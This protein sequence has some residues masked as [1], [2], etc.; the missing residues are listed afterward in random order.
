MKTNTQVVLYGAGLR[1]KLDVFET[2]MCSSLFNVY[3]SDIQDEMASIKCKLVA[4][5]Q[6]SNDL[7]VFIPMLHTFLPKC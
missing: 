7:Y 3:Q 4:I 5:K 6:M 2:P 1:N